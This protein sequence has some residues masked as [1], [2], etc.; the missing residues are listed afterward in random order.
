[1]T[2][3]LH[4][5]TSSGEDPFPSI[6]V[7]SSDDPYGSEN[8]ARACAAAWGSEWIDAGARGHLNA[9]S[10]LGDWAD[11]LKLVEKLQAR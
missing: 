11:E 8:H 10:G 1:M 2:R 6:V 9:Q 3:L 5:Q 7:S 4:R